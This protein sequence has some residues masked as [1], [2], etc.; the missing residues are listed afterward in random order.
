[1]KHGAMIIDISCDRAG[2]VETSVP[3]TIAEPSYIIDG[4]R[5]Y[6]VDHTPALFYKS[7]SEAISSVLP[8]YL[9]GLIEGNWCGNA[10]ALIVRGGEVMDQTIN[11]FQGR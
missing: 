5:H 11:T 8:K 1:M 10:K 2:A 9:D 6:V 7:T 3:T 4:I